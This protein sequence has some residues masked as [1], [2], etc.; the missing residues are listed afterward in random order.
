MICT[1]CAG[2]LWNEMTYHYRDSISQRLPGPI[3]GRMACWYGKD[4]KTQRHNIAHAQKLNHICAP[5]TSRT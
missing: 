3:S 4:C 5:D 2:L 1:A